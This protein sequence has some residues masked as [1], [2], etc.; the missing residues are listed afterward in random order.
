M[1]TYRKTSPAPSSLVA[2]PFTDYADAR[3]RAD[4]LGIPSR[5]LRRM[6]PEG[7]RWLV[8]RPGIPARPSFVR[9]ADWHPSPRVRADILGEVMAR[10]R[11]DIEAP[12]RDTDRQPREVIR[13]PV[14]GNRQQERP[15]EP[16][17]PSPGHVD[18][19]GRTSR[20]PSMQRRER[21]RVTA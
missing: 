2:E 17:K 18:R 19:I 8:I 12:E 14:N 10:I 9:V 3:T 7:L 20:H 13:P 5:P 11:F 15:R 4:A 21:E 1:T 16:F 6:T